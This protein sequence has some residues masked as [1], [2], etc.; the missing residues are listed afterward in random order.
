[1]VPAMV[2]LAHFPLV[3][4]TGTSLAAI[5]LPVGIFGVMAYYRARLIDIRASVLIASGLVISVVVGSGLLIAYRLM[6]C[7]SFTPFSAFT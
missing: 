5:L 1:M 2:L 4:A 6:L 7:A 3:K